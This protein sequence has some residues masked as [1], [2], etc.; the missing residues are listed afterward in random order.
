MIPRNPYKLHSAD[1]AVAL[2]A[3]WL[4]AFTLLGL[5]FAV[6]VWW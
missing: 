4:A 3:L 2:T 5:L 6:R 1:V